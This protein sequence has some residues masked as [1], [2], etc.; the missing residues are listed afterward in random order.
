MT[1]GRNNLVRSVNPQSLFESAYPVLSSAC[2]WNQ[3]DMLMYDA[4]N[5]I[6]NAVTGT[7]S[8]ANLVGVAVQT[9]VNGKVPSPYQGTMVDASQGISDIAGP[10]YGCV[11]SMFLTSGNTFTPGLPV[12][13]GA[14]AQ[15]VTTTAVGSSVGIYQGVEVTP[16]GTGTL[17]N[18]LI[19]A[20]YGLGGIQF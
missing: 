19:G 16:S 17:G 3:G 6:L 9:I 5:N 20:R 12:Y 13:I 14:D 18:V 11:F 2:N 4:T 8:A 7:G 15:T 10:Q 1:Y